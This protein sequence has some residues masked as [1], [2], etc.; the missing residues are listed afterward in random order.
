M[1]D[2]EVG[3]K[4]MWKPSQT[5]SILATKSILD[6]QKIYLIDKGFKFLLTSRFTLNCL[7][8]LFGILRS[9]NIVPNA[10]QVKK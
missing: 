6:I 4:R 1:S 2:L 8:N 9:K 5:G 3:H 7:E 10:L